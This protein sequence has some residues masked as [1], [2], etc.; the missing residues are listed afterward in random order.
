M[1]YSEWYVK[2]AFEYNGCTFYGGK[3]S[4]ILIAY[5]FDLII[6]LTGKQV[7]PVE[8]TELE[9]MHFPALAKIQASHEAIPSLLIDWE[10]FGL[11]DLSRDAW[12]AIAKDI[13]AFCKKKPRA[14]V[15]VFC[16]GG[17]GRTGS[18]LAIL[19]TLLT[20]SKKD[21]IERIRE[22]YRKDA[23]ER[24]SQVMYV[25]YVTGIFSKCEGSSKPT[26]YSKGSYTSSSSTSA[27]SKV[28]EKRIPKYNGKAGQNCLHKVGIRD[29]EGG[30]AFGETSCFHT[31]AIAGCDGGCVTRHA[32]LEKV[33]DDKSEVE[34]EFEI[35]SDASIEIMKACDGCKN[36]T[37]VHSNACN[38]EYWRT[39]GLCGECGR[40]LSKDVHSIECS[41]CEPDEEEEDFADYIEVKGEEVK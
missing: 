39:H 29:C 26:S 2:K 17:I 22:S 5:P 30:C 6:N 27:A 16:T 38:S 18:C 8:L 14:K 3:A 13:K 36:G 23:V 28:E 40:N 33:T 12:L 35:V 1:N 11:C 20:G 15:A 41:Q 10:D 7:L 37:S 31:L 19:K 9:A 34:T 4:E 24:L 32:T 25:S 21:P